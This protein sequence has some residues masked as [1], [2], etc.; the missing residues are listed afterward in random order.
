M[1]L[2]A[3]EF[4]PKELDEAGQVLVDV[5]APGEDDKEW[6]EAFELASQWRATHAGPLRTFRNNL[7]RRVGRRGI[8]AQRLKRMP[9]IISKLGRL[10]WLKLSRMQD[11]GGC[12]AIVPTADD[13]FR[14]AGGLADSKIRHERLDYKN[15]I[16]NPR[17]SGYRGLHLVYGY[18]SESKPELCGLKT[19]LQIRSQLQHQWATAVETVGTFI[20][21]ELKSSEGDETWLRFF[22]LMSS[23]IAQRE[24]SPLIPG[25]PNDHGSLVA[26]IKACARQ[27]GILERLSTFESA[28]H[29]V[30][31]FPNFRNRLIVM[32][33][34][35][36]SNRVEGVAFGEHDTARATAM[37]AEEELMHRGDPKFAVVMVSAKSVQT[38]RRAYPN[39]FADLSD[40]RKLVSE[41]IT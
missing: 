13:A 10:S 2:F 36:R 23:V 5:P 26:E 25:S 29:L 16:D 28:T 24:N 7:G 30:T 19:E 11:I 21:D 27:A 40:F 12:R 17:R 3:D 32:H 1:S 9:T 35:L 38:L 22:A 34:D 39:F 37:Y 15:Y 14:L 4:D 20:G 33:L 6:V 31:D 41:T 18:A 8:V